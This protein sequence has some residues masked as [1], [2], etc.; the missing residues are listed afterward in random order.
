MHSF[1]L[2]RLVYIPSCTPCNGYN[3]SACSIQSSCSTSKDYEAAY[4]LSKH[5]DD[6]VVLMIVLS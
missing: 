6:C 2:M 4:K 1:I 5:H 3:A